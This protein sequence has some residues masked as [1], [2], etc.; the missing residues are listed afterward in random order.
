MDAWNTIGSDY[1]CISFSV[2]D[3]WAYPKLLPAPPQQWRSYNSALQNICLSLPLS[4]SIY[5][6]QYS[7]V[8]S[9]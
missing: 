9:P 2:L 1:R 7:E 5:A 8:F 6:A 3:S 4:L